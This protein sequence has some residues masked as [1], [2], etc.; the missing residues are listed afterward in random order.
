V[1]LPPA[2]YDWVKVGECYPA[3]IFLHRGKVAGMYNQTTINK[4]GEKLRARHH[5]IAAAESVTAG[6]LQATLSSGEWAN[7]FFQGGITAYNLGQ[8]SRHLLVEPIRASS[9]NGISTD[10]AE[11]MTLGVSKP[12]SSDWGVSITGYA[13]PGPELGIKSIFAFYAIAFRTKTIVAKK[14]KMD[15]A[16]ALHVQVHYTNLVLSSLYKVIHEKAWR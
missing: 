15:A 9:C 3:F 13:A 6:H 14:I 16:A 4:I 5:T 10:T 7:D 12:F 2:G 8:K 11:E 1:P